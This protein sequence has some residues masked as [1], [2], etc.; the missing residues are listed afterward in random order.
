MNEYPLGNIVRVSASFE[1]SSGTPMNP[2]AVLVKLK[3]GESNSVFVYGVNSQVRQDVTGTY[4]MDVVA[5]PIGLYT[6]LWYSTGTGQAAKQ[7]NFR[8][9]DTIGN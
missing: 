8:V 6:Y 4:F 3:K 1:S 7:Q 5:D 2:S 9:T